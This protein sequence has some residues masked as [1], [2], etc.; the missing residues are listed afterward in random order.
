MALPTDLGAFDPGQ[1]DSWDSSPL[2]AIRQQAR[3][4]AQAGSDAVRTIVGAPLSLIGGA[5]QTLGQGISAGPGYLYRK[6]IENDP[7][8]AEAYRKER[9]PDVEENIANLYKLIGEP[10][11][12]QGKKFAYETLPDFMSAT[13]LDKLPFVFPEAATVRSR[14]FTPNDLRA[15]AG[16]VQNFSKQ[17][18]D[19]PTDFA[20]AKAGVTRIDPITNAPTLGTKLQNIAPGL[21]TIGELGPTSGSPAAQFGAVR[22]PGTQV[23][24][25]KDPM[26]GNAVTPA[27]AES[28]NLSDIDRLQLAPEHTIDTTQ[29]SRSVLGDYV[30]RYLQSNDLRNGL[31][32]YIDSRLAVEY[33]DAPSKRSA[34]FAFEARH[35]GRSSQS[36]ADAKAAMIDDFVKTPEAQQIAQAQGQFLPTVEDYFNR[37]DA[38]MKWVSNNLSN[39]AAKFVGTSNDPLLKAASEGYTFLPANEIRQLGQ[40]AEPYAEGNRR[41]AGMPGSALQTVIDAKQAELDKATQHVADIGESEAT[42]VVT[43]A[44]E[45]RKKIAQELEN[46]KLGAAYENLADAGV[47]PMPKEKFLNYLDYSERQFYPDVTHPNVPNDATVYRATREFNE[48]GLRSIARSAYNDIMQGKIAPDNLGAKL[49]VDKY[50]RQ[51]SAARMQEEADADAA[52]AA[53]LDNATAAIAARNAADPEAQIIGNAQVLET[54]SNTPRDVALQR[55]SDATAVLDHCV[56]QGGRDVTFTKAKHPFTGNKA[57]YE[58]LRNPITGKKNPNSSRDSS[59]YVDSA[60]SGDTVLAHFNDDQTKLPVAT[61]Q[62][63]KGDN[64]YSLEYVSGPTTSNNDT[65]GPIDPKYHQAIADYLNKRG[66]IAS[67]ESKLGENTSILDLKDSRA[68]ARILGVPRPNDVSAAHPD[69]PRFMPEDALKD[70]AA[71]LKQQQAAPQLAT[72]LSTDT[73]QSLQEARDS[74]LRDLNDLTNTHEQTQDALARINDIDARIARLGTD[75]RLATNYSTPSEYTFNDFAGVYGDNLSDNE[76]R[77]GQAAVDYIHHFFDERSL[78]DNYLYA[79]QQVGEPAIDE[80]SNSGEARRVV[81]GLSHD[82]QDAIVEYFR[83]L[84]ATDYM[85]MPRILTRMTDEDLNSQLRD[86]DRSRVPELVSQM[87]Q[88]FDRNRQHYPS[89][90]AFVDEMRHD[91]PVALPTQEPYDAATLESALRQLA[92]ERMAGPPAAQAPAAIPDILP[93]I[94]ADDWEVDTQHPANQLANNT[95]TAANYAELQQNVTPVQQHLVNDAARRILEQTQTHG[96]DNP[97]EVTNM[98]RNGHNIFGGATLP[99]DTF[100][101]NML[102]LLAR[103]VGDGMTARNNALEH[104]A[105]EDARVQQ[106]MDDFHERTMSNAQEVLEILDESVFS[107]MARPTALRQIHGSIR[108]L[109]NNGHEGW[110]NVLG[111]ASADFPYSTTLR[112]ALVAQLRMLLESYE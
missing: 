10:E 63:Y 87:G 57:M 77:A 66:D 59:S 4:G 99:L 41:A 68:A 79:R 56:G 76:R 98:I 55:A 20:N 12:E 39:Y 24:R 16:E 52:K 6:Y 70:Y 78:Q 21:D 89:I 18:R 28:S 9:M 15:A 35:G 112:D 103:D 53:Y 49:P 14:G 101:L 46:L 85:S 100:S 47:Q 108:Q 43:R 22:V 69:L 8:A 94:L 106:Q 81:A 40:S 54:T 58:P 92:H 32:D 38:G 95:I 65:N 74:A 105:N 51:K 61:L 93:D 75:Q 37:H 11:T 91:R 72:A 34:Q 96:I 62:L 19:I 80:V 67:V 25:A 71:G 26:T 5:A 48:T 2:D 1:G 84:P 3:T 33:P 44:K 107:T 36:Y 111:M 31:Q 60:L 90:L 23:A 86:A 45:K 97:A 88:Y 29:P 104:R 64:G 17:V 27:Q 42:N 50:V 83:D 102:E 82:T 109:E 7:A 110:E 73:L 30:D 13:G